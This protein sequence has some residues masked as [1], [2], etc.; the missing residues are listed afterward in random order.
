MK[1]L[2]NKF[3]KYG[4]TVFSLLIFFVFLVSCKTY[5]QEKESNQPAI[6]IVKSSKNKFFIEKNIEAYWVFD[7]LATSSGKIIRRRNIIVDT[8]KAV[9]E[10]SRPDIIFK[11]NKEYKILDKGIIIEKGKWSYDDKNSILKFIFDEPKYNVPIDKV[12]PELLEKLKKNGSL[13][14]FTENSW[15]IHEITN[16]SLSIIEHLP[17]NEF[18]FKYNLRV[19]RKRK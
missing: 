16:E 15:E 9:E 18:D 12:S 19:Y 11:N 17:H 8:L 6:N 4:S 14:E 7:K 1:I 3:L 5:G 10:V 2:E 13:I